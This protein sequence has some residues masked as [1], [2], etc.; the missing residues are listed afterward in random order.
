MSNKVWDKISYS[1]SEMCV[2]KNF[3]LSGVD[4]ELVVKVNCLE[5]K[6]VELTSK[7]EQLENQNCSF[8]PA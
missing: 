7:I 1:Q 8:T 3:S 2:D 4:G 6:I 5:V